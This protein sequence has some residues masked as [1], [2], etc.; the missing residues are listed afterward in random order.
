MIQINYGYLG[1]TEIWFHEYYNG[2]IEWRW[3]S[4]V[5]NLIRYANSFM[6]AVIASK[7]ELMDSFLRWGSGTDNLQP[8]NSW[9][10]VY[11]DPDQF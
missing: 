4:E 11:Y 7:A 2:E 6:E 9:I 3:S 8:D 1:S 5:D 10:E